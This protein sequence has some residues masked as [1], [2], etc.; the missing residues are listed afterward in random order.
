MKTIRSER[1]GG[2]EVME[3][4]DLPRPSPAPGEVVVAVEAAGFKFS[5]LGRR[6]GLYLDVDKQRT[7]MKQES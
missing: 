3:L 6:R 4:V 1:L 2:P 5:D 7:T